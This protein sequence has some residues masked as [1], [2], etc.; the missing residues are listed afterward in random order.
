MFKTWKE[1]AE[2][3]QWYRAATNPISLRHWETQRGFPEGEW[4]LA[5]RDSGVGQ[6]EVEEPGKYNEEFGEE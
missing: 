4:E 1:A 3:N 6:A 2:A 5:A